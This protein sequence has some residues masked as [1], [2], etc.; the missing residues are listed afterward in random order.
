MKFHLKKN[1]RTKSQAK[2]KEVQT[3]RSITK[4]IQG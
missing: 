1:K 2:D 4:R 3:N